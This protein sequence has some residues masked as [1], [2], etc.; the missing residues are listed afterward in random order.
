MRQN[1][2]NSLSRLFSGC[3]DVIKVTYCTPDSHDV[4][5]FAMLGHGIREEDGLITIY[6]DKDSHS[7]QKTVNI[8]PSIVGSVTYS[9]GSKDG[10]GIYEKCM[11]IG[12]KDESR[13]EIST[14]GMG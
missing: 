1:I 2:I 10:L 11:V 12:M 5:K 4:M 13:I 14:M 3:N 7:M 6:D 9:D 8:D